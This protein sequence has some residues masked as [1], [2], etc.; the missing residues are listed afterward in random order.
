MTRKYE[1]GS[2]PWLAEL[3]RIC[4]EL[5][6]AAPADS[7]AETEYSV[8]EVYTDVP[9]RIG[10]TGRVSWYWRVKSGRL[11]V[12]TTELEHADVKI[13]VDYS[14]VV[15][16]GRLIFENDAAAQSVADNLVAEAMRSGKMTLDHTQAEM[17][18]PFMGLHDALAQITA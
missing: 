6:A 13:V 10:P 12:G 5:F 3:R 4:E 15:P 18:A 9:T 2:S 11:D 14:T 8:C 17:P 7:L 16:I 1:M